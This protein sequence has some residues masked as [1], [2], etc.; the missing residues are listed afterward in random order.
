MSADLYKELYQ[1][2]QNHLM[3]C[4]QHRFARIETFNRAQ[5]YMQGLMNQ[6]KRRNGWQIAEQIGDQTPDG[7]QR[8]LNSA[9]WDVDGVR[10]DLQIEAVSVLGNKATV[11]VIDETGFLKKGDQSAGVKRQYSGTAGRVENCQIGVFLAYTTETGHTLIDRELYLPKDWAA[12]EVRRGAAHIP[13]AVSFETK[14]ALARQML[15]RAQANGVGFKWVTAD[16]IYSSDRR[17]R[18]WLE[19]QQQPFVMAVKR[20][21]ALWC[22][23]EQQRA[24]ELIQNLAEGDW[25]RLSAGNE[26]KGPRWYDWAALTL[27]R[28]QQDPA[29]VHAL[30]VRRSLSD[31]SVLTYYVVYA[32]V[33]TKIHEW[34]RVAGQRGQ[35]QY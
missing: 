28:Y 15:E 7:V 23:F 19:T 27:P 6:I 20:D 18:R 12:H 33:D 32:P 21:E 22:G 30:L 3:H 24:D 34:V 25:Y 2:I 17:L 31:P 9:R 26:S 13:D 4:I 1:Q 5:R 14:P 16:S 35:V 29:W 11:G 8:L 10:N